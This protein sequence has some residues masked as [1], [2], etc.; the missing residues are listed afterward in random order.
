M[1]KKNRK[2]KKNQI[3]A[4]LQLEKKKKKASFVALSNIFQ[5]KNKNEQ[6]Q[7]LCKYRISKGLELI[8]LNKKE[9]SLLY[10]L[11]I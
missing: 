4:F 6:K 7:Y 5:I 11:L 3:K 9:K 10:C 1:K 2:E 8:I